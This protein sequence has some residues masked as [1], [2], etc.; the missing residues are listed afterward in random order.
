M[1]YDSEQDYV[2]NLKYTLENLGYSV[3][4]EVVPD[5]CE[6]WDMP[7][8]VDLIFYRADFGYVGVEAKNTNT[9]GAGA[10]IYNAIKQIDEKYR[11]K[12][13]FKGN[14]IEKWALLV[15]NEV[16]CQHLPNYESIKNAIVIFLRGFISQMNMNLLEY[17]PETKWKK[18]RIVVGGCTKNKI[19]IGGDSKWQNQ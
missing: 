15:P 9:L 16:G 3:W 13:Y 12:T 1:K 10:R 6:G 8:R 2:D 4:T 5:Q 17:S 18:A 14:I 7:Y 19:E 11:N